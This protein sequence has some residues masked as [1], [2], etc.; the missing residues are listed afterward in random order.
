MSDMISREAMTASLE[1]YFSETEATPA[2]PA[3]WRYPD[4]IHPGFY[5]YATSPDDLPP[6]AQPLYLE[7]QEAAP[8][9][10]GNFVVTVIAEKAQR[11]GFRSII[12]HALNEDEAIGKAMRAFADVAPG[13]VFS[14]PAVLSVFLPTDPPE[15]Q[16]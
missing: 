15:V 12:L 5:I 9:V 13:W 2:A 4:P 16:K 1:S 11:M 10:R 8:A 6:E 3:A 7:G 14:K